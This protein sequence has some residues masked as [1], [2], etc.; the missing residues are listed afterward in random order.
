MIVEKKEELLKSGSQKYPESFFAWPH[1][2]CIFSEQQHLSLFRSS[3][4][5]GS[6]S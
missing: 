4:G 3:P 5:G 6:V 2:M 1:L